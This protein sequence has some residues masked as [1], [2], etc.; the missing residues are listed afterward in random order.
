[1]VLIPLLAIPLSLVGVVFLIL[2]MGFSLNLLTLLAMVIAIGLVVDDAIVVVEN[3]HRHIED[4][5]SPLQAA[6]TGTREVALPV[7]AMTLTLAAV[8]AP[9]AFIGGLTGALFTEF[10]LTL[11]GAVRRIRRRRPDPEPDAGLPCPSSRTEQGRFADSLDRAFRAVTARY[12]RLLAACLDHRGAVLV[13]SIG[14]LLSLP[15]LYLVSQRELA[16]EEDTGSIYVVG[17]APSYANL[18]YIVRFL[19]EVV[20][21]WRD[22]PE[23]ASSWQVA[24]PDNNFGGSDDGALGRA[25]AHAAGGAGGAAG[26]TGG[27]RG[28]GDVQLRHAAAAR[29]RRGTPGQLRGRL[30]GGLRTCRGRGSGDRARGTGIG[31]VHLRQPDPEVQ[32]ARGERGD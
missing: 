27:H 22:M 7:L 20:K 23:I 17:S 6:L 4:G 25:R 28:Y 11:A 2:V 5:V 12:R 3:V 19:D 8:Y 29:V 32:S 1:V 16:P 31:P 24:Q 26:K 21:I 18:D 9:I 13:F 15:A 10:A 30:H 14:I